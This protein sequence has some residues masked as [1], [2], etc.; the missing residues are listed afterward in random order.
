MKRFI[1]FALLLC[2]LAGCGGN[3]GSG[4]GSNVP[5]PTFTGAMH[6]NKQ[7]SSQKGVTICSGDS[8]GASVPQIADQ[9]LD[10]LFRIAE[11]ARII[12]TLVLTVS[13]TRKCLALARTERITSG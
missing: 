4:G 1:C 10:D 11:A 2:G 13:G 3:S 5:A 8:I 9:Q 6:C 12:I 7:V